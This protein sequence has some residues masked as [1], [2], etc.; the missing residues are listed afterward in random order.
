MLSTGHG[1]QN[2]KDGEDPKTKPYG[3]GLSAGS[4]NSAAFKGKLYNERKK[5]TDVQPDK[6]LPVRCLTVV[7]TAQKTQFF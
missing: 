7:S 1:M 5:P 3:E 6:E 4:T 2:R